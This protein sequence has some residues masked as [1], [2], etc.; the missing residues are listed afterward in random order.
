MQCVLL[1]NFE[2]VLNVSNAE[3]ADFQRVVLSA[4]AQCTEIHTLT[5]NSSATDDAFLERILEVL[6]QRNAA[7]RYGPEII[8]IENIRIREKGIASLCSYLEA[9]CVDTK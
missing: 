5:L 7:Q 6:V 8:D 3:M 2:K 1:K 9:D 4:I